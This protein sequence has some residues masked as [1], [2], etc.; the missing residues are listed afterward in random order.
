LIKIDRLG[1]A[2][3]QLRNEQ[4]RRNT[5]TGQVV[6]SHQLPVQP[7]QW[8]VVLAL[9][10]D[11]AGRTWPSIIW[12]GRRWESADTNQHCAQGQ[13]GGET[14]G[15]GLGHGCYL[16]E[17]SITARLRPEVAAHIDRTT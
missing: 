11:N 15:R 9:H 8:A 6:A 4:W 1:S 10:H 17:E 14:G 13:G 3:S 16:L 12:A 2:C 7:S 5:V